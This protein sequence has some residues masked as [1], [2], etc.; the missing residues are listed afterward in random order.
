MSK[1]YNL[2]ENDVDRTWYDSSNVVYT[3]CDDITNG[4]KVLRIYFKSG[5]VY[6]YTNVNVNDYLLFR[7]DVSQGRA[8][9][10]LIKNYPCER[11]EDA[12]IQAI[13]DKREELENGHTKKLL[14]DSI[15]A[16]GN[17]LSEIKALK[18][19]IKNLNPNEKQLACIMNDIND[20]SQELVL[21]DFCNEDI[22]LV[23]I[24]ELWDNNVSLIEEDLSN[25]E[26]NKK[27]RNKLLYE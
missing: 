13:I 7:E 4:L 25:E 16:F 12:D 5:R 8:F 3:E 23:N 11:L 17:I 20:I 22:N 2:Y 9:T 6:Q 15:L 18:S 14:I 21:T 19:T 26:I 27:V 24:K 10:K 1:I